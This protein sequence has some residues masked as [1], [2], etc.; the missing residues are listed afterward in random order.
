[1]RLSPV[2][3]RTVTLSFFVSERGIYLVIR[4]Y[5]DLTRFDDAQRI[6]VPVEDDGLHPNLGQ[7]LPSAS[8]SQSAEQVAVLVPD[9]IKA[10]SS[11]AIRGESPHPSAAYCSSRTG[12]STGSVFR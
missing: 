6:A 4:P 1:V 10:P 2:F 12:E 8:Y 5:L 9:A 11:S 7:S 3:Q